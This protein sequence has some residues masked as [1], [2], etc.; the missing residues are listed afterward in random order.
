MLSIKTLSTKTLSIMTL[1]LKALVIMTLGTMRIRITK[2]RHY[3]A[4]KTLSHD[5]IRIATLS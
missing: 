4:Q 1:G 3:D 2:N 5:T